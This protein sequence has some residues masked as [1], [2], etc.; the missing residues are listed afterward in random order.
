MPDDFFLQKIKEDLYLAENKM[1]DKIGQFFIEKLVT[2]EYDVF[3]VHS[4]NDTVHSGFNII[5]STKKLP[6]VIQLPFK[7]QVDTKPL[8]IALKLMKERRHD[9]AGLGAPIH[10]LQEFIIENK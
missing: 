9:T 1:S 4:L 5:A 3:E 6:S 2:N 8:E 10:L 7:R